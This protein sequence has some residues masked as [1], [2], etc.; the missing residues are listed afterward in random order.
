MVQV[1]GDAPIVAIHCQEER[2]LA[3]DQLSHRPETAFPFARA[4]PFDLHDV[5]AH[6]SEELRGPRAH[7][8]LRE[9]ENSNALERAR[10]LDAPRGS[11]ARMLSEYHVSSA[12]RTAPASPP[13]RS[14]ELISSP[15]R[16]WNSSTPSYRGRSHAASRAGSVSA[17]KPDDDAFTA[18]SVHAAR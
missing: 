12:L 2:A 18:G 7:H 11:P 15:P 13:S 14:H 6:V 16:S 4:G 10:H 3:V 17:K 1:D 9:V 8:H 5:G